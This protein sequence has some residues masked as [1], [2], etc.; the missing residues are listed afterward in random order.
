MNTLYP[1]FRYHIPQDIRQ[2]KDR[3]TMKIDDIIINIYED[4]TISGQKDNLDKAYVLNNSKNIAFDVMRM[5][6][7]VKIN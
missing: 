7:H 5:I 6:E 2:Y 4:N 3:F 1:V